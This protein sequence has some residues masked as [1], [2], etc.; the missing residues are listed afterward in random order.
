MGGYSACENKKKKNEI[1][2]VR[3]SA[4]EKIWVWKFVKCTNNFWRRIFRVYFLENY[5]YFCKKIIICTF[6]TKLD[7][8]K[9]SWRIFDS[10]FFEN[11]GFNEESLFSLFDSFSWFDHPSWD[12]LYKN[13]NTDIDIAKVPLFKHLII[14][15]INK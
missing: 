10:D 12:T 9:C 6:S 2:F 15:Y 7:K 3:Y 4:F 8:F 11:E 14:H 1:F 5:P 13:F